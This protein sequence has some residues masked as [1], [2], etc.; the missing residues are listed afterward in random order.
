MQEN[1]LRATESTAMPLFGASHLI[2]IGLLL[3]FV[4]LLVY[5][6][7]SSIAQPS[8]ERLGEIIA[9]TLFATFPTYLIFQLLDGTLTWATALPLYPCPLSSL[10]APVLV[11]SRN[12]KLFN[13]IFYWVFAGTVQAV[14]TPEIKFTFPHY[15]YF[16]FW[17]CHAG[18]L[19][20]LAFTL[21]LQEAEPKLSGILPA[22]AWFNVLIVVAAVVN[23]LVATNYY[24][25]KAKPVVPTLIDYLGPWPWYILGVE[26]VAL[27][28]FFLSF[29]VFWFVK[30]KV[31]GSGSASS[32]IS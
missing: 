2:P 21:I 19:A 5:L 6:K 1:A 20:L 26:G 11:R 27:T 28:Q 32:N 14:I 3:L 18:L 15:E 24:Y 10:L 4:T 25:L 30:N 31:V 9:W 13:V 17:V 7:K 29:A 12:T 8:L 16:Y 22:F 23:S